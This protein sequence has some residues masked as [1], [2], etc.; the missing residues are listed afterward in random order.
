M[1]RN[2]SAET[3]II[4]QYVSEI[5]DSCVQVDQLRF[6]NNLTRIG[7]IIAFEISKELDYRSKSISTVLGSCDCQVLAQEPVLGTILRAGLPLYQGL[8]NIFDR[9]DNAFISAFRKAT[10]G[11]NFEI[12]LGYVA[13]PNLDNRILIVADPMLATG[14]SMIDTLSKLMVYGTPKQIHVVTAIACQVGIDLLAEHLP[15]AKIWAAAV[16]RELNDHFYIVPGLGDAG[17]LA[18]GKKLQG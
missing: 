15:D 3:S 14:R 8:L 7:E 12:E 2:L 6:R 9:A 5:R 4:T 18:Y 10:D 13:C 11:N 17:D 16:D 1:L